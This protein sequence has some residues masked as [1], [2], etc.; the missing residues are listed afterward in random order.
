MFE[1]IGNILKIQEL[2]K[3]ILITLS[4]LI[5]YRTGCFIPT[6][7]VDTFALSQ[8]FDKIAK[9][10]GQTLLGMVN[11][12]TGGALTR[13]SIFALGIM[14]YISASIIMQLL[15]AVIPSLERIAKEGKAGY[16]KIN[17]YTRYFT[18]VLCVVQGLFLSLWLQNPNNFQGI[19]IVPNPGLAFNLLTILTLTCG[20]VFIM[21]LGEQIQERGIGNGRNSY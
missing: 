6:A 7:G 17:Q 16:E 4:L 13:L 11:L 19:V 9:T 12:F 5:V 10:Q 2:K 18:F 15:T 21:W 14:P 3:K 1:A 20:T 8:F